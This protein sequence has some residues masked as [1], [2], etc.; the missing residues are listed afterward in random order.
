[1]RVP[2]SSSAERSVF[3]RMMTSW[4]PQNVLWNRHYRRNGV[5]DLSPDDFHQSCVTTLSADPVLLKAAVF[6]NDREY[7]VMAAL[8]TSPSLTR[9]GV[10]CEA[11]GVRMEQG[12]QVGGGARGDARD[13]LGLPFLDASTYR[14]VRVLPRRLHTFALEHAH[15]PRER[16]TYR[17]PLVICPEASF[18]GA[19]QRGRYSAAVLSEDTVFTGSFVGVSSAGHD[20]LLA[21]VLALI[22]NSKTVAFLLALGGSNTGLKQPKIEKVRS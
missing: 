18:A 7:E 11:H 3:P 20:P 6:G 13:L 8:Q 16:E 2:L 10:W 21:D 15:R 1:M 17:A 12:L 9:L 22:L 14:P 5:L 19:L 4:R